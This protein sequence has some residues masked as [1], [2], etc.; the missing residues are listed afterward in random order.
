MRKAKAREAGLGGGT[1]GA[2]S[3]GCGR[4]RHTHQALGTSRHFHGRSEAERG[5]APGATCSHTSALRS[6]NFLCAVD[7][8]SFTN[9]GGALSSSSR[10]HLAHSPAAAVSAGGRASL[11]RRCAYG[12]VS[13]CDPAARRGPPANIDTTRAPREVCAVNT[14]QHDGRA[15]G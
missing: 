3:A 4:H 9:H 8:S 7:G 14:E 15:C 6:N 11:R 5:A 12:E 2:H 13:R 10:Q 1:H